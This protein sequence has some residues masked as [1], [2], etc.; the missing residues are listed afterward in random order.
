[1]LKNTRVRSVVPTPAVSY[2]VCRHNTRRQ[3]QCLLSQHPP[4]AQCLLSQHPPSAQ[5]LL[6][7]HPLSAQCLSP[8]HPSSATATDPLI[9]LASAA[10]TYA[11]VRSELR[12]LVWRNNRT[13]GPV[14]VTRRKQH[15]HLLGPAWVLPVH[16]PPKTTLLPGFP[17]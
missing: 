9:D 6:S 5:C 14:P 8:Q 12:L 17:R 7:Q 10:V 4:S 13:D 3:L 2:S 15:V 1:M 11:N 16:G